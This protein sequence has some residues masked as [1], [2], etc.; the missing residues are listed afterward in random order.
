MSPEGIDRLTSIRYYTRF[1]ILFTLLPLLRAA[2]S[3]CVISVLAGGQEGQLWPE[4]WAMEKHWGVANAGGVSSSLTTFMF[5]ALSTNKENKNIEFIHLFPGLVRDTGLKFEG[6]GV[7][8]GFLLSWIVLPI[9][10]RVMEYSIVEAGER[11]LYAATRGL[12]GVKGSNGAV[13]SGVYLV[14]GDSAVLEI[15]RV[16]KKM[17]EE[18]GMVE[19]VYEHTMEV[20]GGV[21]KM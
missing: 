18:E 11:V 14:G 10:L 9:V 1:R 3:P 19:K 15:P 16:A 21:D 20:F 12:E 4:G 17:R 2:K 13:G 7:I 8:G 5:E 6:A